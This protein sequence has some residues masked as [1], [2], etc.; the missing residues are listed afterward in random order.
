MDM[1]REEALAH[2]G[3]PGM[4]WGV[5]KD[6]VSN[7]KSVNSKRTPEERRA[8]AKKIAIGTGLLLVAA[9]S[10]YAVHTLKQNGSN[11]ISSLVRTP[12]AK[13]AVQKVLEEPTQ[14][15]H[16]SKPSR[17]SG[18]STTSLRFIQTGGMK[19]FFSE[20]EQFET[21][22]NNSMVRYGINN[23]K[24]AANLL[25]PKGRHD[26]A[27]RLVNHMIIVPKSIARDINTIDDVREKIWPV[28]EF[29]YEQMVSKHIAEERRKG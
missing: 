18:A 7:A 27:G 17:E 15:I 16:H 4:K 25:D 6:R 9:G 3:V 28:L 8:L 24:V 5:R 2:F 23:E 29:D 12:A 22:P 26:A 10:A 1:S 21:L 11:P 19:N 13:Q 14:L 20:I